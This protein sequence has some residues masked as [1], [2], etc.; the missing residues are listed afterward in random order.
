MVLMN[1]TSIAYSGTSATLGAN[2]QVTFSA[3]TSLSLNGCFTADFDNYVVSLRWQ[4][5]T[6]EGFNV[7]LRAAGTDN[8]TASSYVSQ[9]LD[10][11]STTVGANRLTNN[12]WFNTY[13]GSTNPAG[14][15]LN[16][17]GPFLAQPTAIRGVSVA[18][19]SSASIEDYA[20]T[21]NQ[22]TSYDGMTI[23]SSA[24][25]TG[26]VQVYGVRS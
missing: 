16:L 9:R 19:V 25:L 26:A 11:S 15:V 21:H 10:A 23:Y 17:Y 2:G 13:S 1:P 20:G 4:P 12:Y 14:N 7:R 18:T 24:S 5:S 8:T 22:S 3:V 6:A